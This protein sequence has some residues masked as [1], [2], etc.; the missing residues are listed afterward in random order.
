MSIYTCCQDQR[1]DRVRDQRALNGID[2]LEVVDD[3]A[4]SEIERQRQL[5]VRFIN[6]PPPQ[7]SESP[8][9]KSIKIRCMTAMFWWSI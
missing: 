9:S 3:D 2:F 7:G 8:I 5:R 4:P 6:S 1:R